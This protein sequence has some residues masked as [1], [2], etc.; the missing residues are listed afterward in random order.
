MADNLENRGPA[1]R[2]R[3]SLS[4][5]WEVTYWTQALG[6]SEE[7]LRAAV[8]IAGNSASAVRQHLGK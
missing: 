4:E 6:V 5:R 1:D 7:A 3:I 8:K 2:S